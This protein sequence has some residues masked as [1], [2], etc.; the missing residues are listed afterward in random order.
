MT[1]V[2]GIRGILGESMNPEIAARFTAAFASHIKGGTVVVGRDTRASGAYL[3]PVVFAT[4]QFSGIDVI[5]LGIAP[6]P[7]VG[8]MVTE[9]ETDGGIV[10]T[11]SH[12]GPE[13]NALKLLRSS[14]EFLTAHEMREVIGL[15]SGDRSL[16]PATDRYGALS[17]QRNAD[18]IHIARILDLGLIDPDRIRAVGFRVVV[19]CVNGAGSGI[20]PSLLRRLGT[21]VFEIFTD[22]DAPFPHV[23]E[24]RP[25][26]LG[27]LSDAVRDNNADIGFAC[28]PDADRLVLVDGA[29]RVCSEELT[30]ALAADFVLKHERGP[31]VANLSTSRII[32]DIGREYGVEVHRSQ[33]GEANVIEVMKKSGAVVGGEGNGGVIYPPVHYG[34][35]AMTGIALILQSLAEEDISLHDKVKNLPHYTIVKRKYPFAGDLGAVADELRKRFPGN[36]NTIDGIRI[37]ME[38]GWIHLRSSNT[39]PVVRIIAEAGMEEEALSLARE[40]E[41]VL[42]L[43]TGPAS[44]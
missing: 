36:T 31:L 26:N 5:D 39:E 13:W 11:A 23:P 37:D 1:S 6:T 14:G 16:F 19:D 42:Q 28:D 22:M 32:D 25:E 38:T 7:T 9:L 15:A 43:G 33:V 18:D 41:A 2:S 29:G 10:I 8:I 27:A 12:N 3:A 30:L 17:V 4:L 20:I 40:A 34:R 24:P 44:R 35:D 21:E